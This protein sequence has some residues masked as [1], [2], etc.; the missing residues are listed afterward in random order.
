[1]KYFVLIFTLLLSQ[2]VSAIIVK[3]K[4]KDSKTGEEIIGATLEIKGNTSEKAVSGLD[5]SFSILADKFPSTIVCTF[6]GYKRSEYTLKKNEANIIIPI[7]QRK[8]FFRQSLKR[9][10]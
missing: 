3:G 6:I 9:K 7:V 10:R 8:Q 2:V 5:G 4:V 1:M